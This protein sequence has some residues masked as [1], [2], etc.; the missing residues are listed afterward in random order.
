MAKRRNSSQKRGFRRGLAGSSDE[1]PV[2]P[3]FLVIGR[4]TKPHGVR[5]EVR[6]ALY[7]DVPERFG[8]LEAAYLSA[9]E[10]DD[11]LSPTGVE[12]ARLHGDVVLL[13]LAGYDDREAAQALRNLWV[14]VPVDEAV[15]LEEGEYYLFQLLGLDVVETAGEP[16]GK[17]VDIL[18][19]GAHN[20]LVV[21]GERGEVLL[22]DIPDVIQ[23]I[24]FDA[25]QI[26][27][28]LLPGL[29]P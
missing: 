2:K 22:P 26:T 13:K 9:D 11:D 17:V 18:E 4:I 23:T 6:V 24:D 21:K 5:G 7:T 16:L 20:V 14:Q 27:V 29:L 19:T 28:T 10:W 25:N 8:W 12:Y 15:P 1:R 3:R